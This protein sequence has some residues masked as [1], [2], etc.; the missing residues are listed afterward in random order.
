MDFR[1]ARKDVLMEA[2]LSCLT[3]GFTVRVQAVGG[4][5]AL[6]ALLLPFFIFRW[7][8]ESHYQQ[9]WQGFEDFWPNYL[10]CAASSSE[11]HVLSG[12]LSYCASCTGVGEKGLMKGLVWR[13]CFWWCRLAWAACTFPR[14]TGG[15]GFPARPG[16]GEWGAS[17]KLPCS[18]LHLWLCKC[19]F[20]IMLVKVQL[21]RLIS[22]F[23]RTVKA[24]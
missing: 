8:A 20:W 7:T 14:C 6:P 22:F 23:I 13:V 2:G 24:D 18:G 15:V 1:A 11:I 19:L 10:I 12:R 3:D 4:E 5:G 21:A 9:Q 17:E 16:W